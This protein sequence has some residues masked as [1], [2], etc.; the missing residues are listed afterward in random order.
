MSV[1]DGDQVKSNFSVNKMPDT[2]ERDTLGLDDFKILIFLFHSF[3]LVMK[4]LSVTLYRWVVYRL[5]HVSQFLSCPLLH[6]GRGGRCSG[7]H[8]H[9]QGKITVASGLNSNIDG[10][11]SVEMFNF[12]YY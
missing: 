4:L 10:C 11:S 5:C 6:L 8:K 9:R 7:Q 12:S 3:F 1:A 2:L